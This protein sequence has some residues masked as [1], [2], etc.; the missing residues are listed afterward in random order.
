MVIRNN[1]ISEIKNGSGIYIESSTCHL[2]HNLIAKN[3]QDGIYVTTNSNI[4][5]TH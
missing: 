1:Q 4:L 2:D 5:A 3:F